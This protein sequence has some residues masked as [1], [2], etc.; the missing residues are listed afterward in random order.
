MAKENSH[1]LK[2]IHLLY[3]GAGALLAV[4]IAWG[5]MANQ[6]RT[7]TKN[8]AKNTEKV[9]T[10]KEMLVRIDTRQEVVIKGIDEIKETLKK[11]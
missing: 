5:T 7:D 9:T 2:L 8:I 10:N 1:Q 6:Q 4:G 11:K 3:I